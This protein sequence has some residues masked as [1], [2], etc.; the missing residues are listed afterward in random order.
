MTDPI[1][2]VDAPRC[3]TT[4]VDVVNVMRDLCDVVSFEI[5]ETDPSA[6][7]VV[8]E[9]STHYILVMIDPV[10]GLIR[11]EC[12]I[13]DFDDP[14]RN[15]DVNDYANIDAMRAWLTDGSGT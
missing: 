14:D 9:L 3:A 12:D 8:R 5:H 13:C 1:T 15:V 2:Y 10:T 6:K 4:I 11:D 7:V